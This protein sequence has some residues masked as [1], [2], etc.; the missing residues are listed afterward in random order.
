MGSSTQAA[1]HGTDIWANTAGLN[2]GGIAIT[3][4]STSTPAYVT[5]DGV[6][7]YD[8]QA[9][10][11]GGGIFVDTIGLGAG[12]SLTLT[13]DTDI[14]DNEVVDSSGKGGGVYFG[15]G[16]ITLQGVSITTNTATTGPQ[17]YRV[18]GT[19]LVDDPN[20]TN[21]YTETVGS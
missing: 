13:G 11:K 2:G 4:S 8:N 10:F 16:T 3:P 1:I 7:I 15:A 12:V 18:T 21:T 5:L 19:T 6:G 17:M 9:Q 20:Y 14:Y